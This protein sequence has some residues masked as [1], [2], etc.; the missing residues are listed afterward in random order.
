M[1]RGGIVLCGGRSTRMGLDKATLPFGPERMLQRVVRLLGEAVDVIVVVAA[2][3]QELPP[4]PGSV[5]L[6]RDQRESRGPLE[7]LFAGLGALPPGI[8]AAYATSC[9]T[10]S[11]PRL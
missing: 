6:A 4:L 11:V 9:A 10:T 8:E 3:G 2:P 5:R 7:G 1:A